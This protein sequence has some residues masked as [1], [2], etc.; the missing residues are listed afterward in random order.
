[1][2]INNSLM[3]GISFL[4]LIAAVAATAQTNTGE[5]AVEQATQLESEA[6]TPTAAEADAT[7]VTQ[8][9]SAA[10]EVTGD[11]DP[12][13]ISYTCVLQDLQR[14]VEVDYLD[15]VTNTPC[16]VSYYKDVETPGVKQTLWS[17]SS[18]EGYCEQQAAT[19]VEKLQGW[20]WSCNSQ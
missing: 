1:M 17:A 15:P 8:E 20:G 13:T 18:A 4:L 11:T 2:T 14:R 7:P 16:E 12:R 5:Q 19:F 10:A 6:A 9:E 3:S